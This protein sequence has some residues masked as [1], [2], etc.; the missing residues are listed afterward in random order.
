MVKTGI[1]PLEDEELERGVDRLRTLVYP[2][3]PEAY[4]TE[5]HDSVWH[6]L[7]THPLAG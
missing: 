4:D 6:W 3:H 5:W 2:E 1:R 7:G